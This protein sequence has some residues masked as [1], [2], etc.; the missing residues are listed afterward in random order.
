MNRSLRSLALAALL[1]AGL[2]APPALRAQ[3]GS[4]S[5]L[6]LTSLPMQELPPVLDTMPVVPD[7]V[8]T[9]PDSVAAGV[10]LPA[11]PFSLAWLKQFVVINQLWCAMF[12][13]SAML[14]AFA[15]YWPGFAGISDAATIVV[16][17][18]IG[19]LLSY[20]VTS[21]GGK[22]D[23]EINALI[24]TGMSAIASGYI[25]RLGKKQPGNS[26]PPK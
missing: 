10:V 3:E 9:P 6:L 15:K 14:F 23:A 19:W 1:L 24:T 26:A 22:P 13:T 25:F 21:W 2:T 7:T 20:A 4:T 11:M 8:V 18:I 17:L 12:L 16:Q 5:L